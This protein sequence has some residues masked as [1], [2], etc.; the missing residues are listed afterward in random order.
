MNYELTCS[1]TLWKMW[2]MYLTIHRHSFIDNYHVMDIGQCYTLK[3][4]LTKVLVQLL[5]V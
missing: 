1:R 2:R 4:V 5:L 3:L